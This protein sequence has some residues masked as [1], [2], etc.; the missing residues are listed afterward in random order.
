MGAPGRILVGKVLGAVVAIR[1]YHVAD[2][3][4]HLHASIRTAFEVGDTQDIRTAGQHLGS[5]VRSV[6]SGTWLPLGAPRALAP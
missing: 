6:Y 1:A 2:A 5:S 3:E 4:I